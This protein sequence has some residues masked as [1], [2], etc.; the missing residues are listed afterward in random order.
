MHKRYKIGI[1]GW[2]FC[3]PFTGIGRYSLNVFSEL[4]RNFP[5]LEFH[6]AIPSRLDDDI[7]KEL[8]Y[9][10][11]LRFEVVPENMSLKALHPG[12]AKAH[13]EAGQL[14]HFFRS[15]RV[16]LIHLPYPCLYKRLPGVPVVVTVHDTIPWT[17]ERYR[18]RGALSAYY[19]KL[20]LRGAIRSD[21]VV[22]V[23]NTSKADILSLKG[24][25]H[26]KLSVVYNASEFNEVPE[27][28]EESADA[29]LEG[30]GVKP[31]EKFLFYMGGFDARKNVSRLVE[32]YLRYILPETDLKLVL[33]GGK[34][35][36]NN[37]FKDVEDVSPRIIRT[38][39]LS[40]RELITL[41]K[42]AW[43]F[44]SLTTSEGFD[45]SLLESITLGCPALVSD[46]EVHREI[47][48]TAPLFLSLR[49]GD[50]QIAENVL[51]LYNDG[52][53]YRE[54]KQKT[55][56]YA[57]KARDKYSWQK[58]AKQIGEIYLKLI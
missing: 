12:L 4:A 20:S 37:L 1:N 17:D 34:V 3:K 29:L 19:N 5:E 25:D 42:K 33:G 9:Q 43:A 47:A 35:L 56:E 38:G 7:D 44:I 32:V 57:E 22:T 8:R 18:K 30:Y 11:N 54:L 41:Y 51:S 27:L 15:A 24:F 55:L 26:R 39:F 23:S 53:A 13:W 50:K 45:L 49:G 14:K 48:G 31:D 2:F 40:N 52:A 36:D 46:I 21:Y 16:D 58:T 10:E 6:V 28:S